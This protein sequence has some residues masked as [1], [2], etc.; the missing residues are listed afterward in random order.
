M[1]RF[2]DIYETVRRHHPGADLD[3]LRKAYIFSAVEHKGQTRA[4]GE[5]YLVH[6]LEVANIL[7]EMRMDP[8]CVAVGLLHDVLEDTLTDADRISNRALTDYERAVFLQ[9]DQE[10]HVAVNQ[11]IPKTEMQGHLYNSVRLNGQ[12][13]LLPRPLSFLVSP[14]AQE[15]TSAAERLARLLCLYD[16]AG[17]HFL[18][19]Q[20]T[21][22]TPGTVL[23]VCRMRSALV[24]NSF[25]SLPNNL[26]A[27]CARTPD[28]TS[29][30]RWAIN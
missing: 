8:A 24:R 27:T 26:M 17:E 25:K 29:S 15:S 4:S 6:P 7:A 2:E 19:G 23:M 10:K 30:M 20:D 21:S 9:H 1:I 5:P 14:G 11:L 13:V 16:N 12:S 28:C 22:T 18:P 3:L